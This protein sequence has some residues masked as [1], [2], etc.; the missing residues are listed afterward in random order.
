MLMMLGVSQFYRLVLGLW[1]CVAIRVP[2]V[3]PSRSHDL[4]CL[5]W[6]PEEAAGTVLQI[7]VRSFV[8]L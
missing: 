5:R 4:G 7:K 8:I 3:L 2:Q 6:Y 1:I